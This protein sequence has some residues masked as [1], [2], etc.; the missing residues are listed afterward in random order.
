MCVVSTT[1]SSPSQCPWETPM[2]VGSWSPCSGGAQIDA[3][4]LAEHLRQ[5]VD[6]LR[7]SPRSRRDTA[8][9]WSSREAGC[10]EC[11]RCSR[12]PA[13][14]RS[15]CSVFVPLLARGGH[16]GREWPLAS[17]QR[18]LALASGNHTPE[19]SGRAG[20]CSSVPRRTQPSPAP[21]SA[22]PQHQRSG[23]SFRAS[24]LA[25]GCGML[26][27]P[28]APELGAPHRIDAGLSA[29]RASRRP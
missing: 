10:R 14:G 28:V 13:S 11:T 26:L 15:A 25:R 27:Q 12:R 18:P 5:L 1:S 4:H 8:G 29:G 20:S 23:D 9:W 3:P 16:R 24:L 22:Q 21:I 2:R 6:A 7:A 19:K 17:G